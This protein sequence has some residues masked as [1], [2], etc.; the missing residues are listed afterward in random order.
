MMGGKVTQVGAKAGPQGGYGVKGIDKC[1]RIMD[2]GHGAE[3]FDCI[4]MHGNV[5]YM[6]V[7]QSCNICYWTHTHTHIYIRGAC[8]E[9]VMGC[10]GAKQRHVEQ[11]HVGVEHTT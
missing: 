11:R 3:R 8:S 9:A 10:I 5:T 6:Y 2:G 4:V 1:M 7:L